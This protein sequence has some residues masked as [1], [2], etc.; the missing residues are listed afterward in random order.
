MNTQPEIRLGIGI[1]AHNEAGTLPSLV[2]SLFQQSIF[3][4][5]RPRFAAIHVVCIPNGCTDDTA[6]V[7]RAC[8]DKAVATLGANNVSCAVEELSTA[9]KANAWNHCIHNAL[10]AYEFV[11][12]LDADILFAS[13]DTIQAALRRV[14]EDA[15]VCVATDLPLK[16][17][18]DEKA[19]LVGRLSEA[20]SRASPPGPT[21]ICGQFYCARASVLRSIWI[22][23]GLP[24]EDG[25]LRAMVITNEFRQAEDPQR[26]VRADGASHFFESKR[27]LRELWRHKKRLMIGTTLNILLFQHLWDHAGEQGAGQLLRDHS[28]TDP[29]WLSQY[30]SDKVSRHYWVV[31][32]GHVLRRLGALRELPVPKAMKRVPVAL[33]ATVLDLAV[34]LSANREIKRGVGL[35]YW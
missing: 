8:L 17:P 18:G 15:R 9:G 26:I 25:F 29:S 4:Q 7:A 28:K 13:S 22:P 5:H 30:L 10:T 12:L 24:V 11:C 34:A 33:A 20:F 14:V 23:D 35:G 31:P 27:S 1:L 2:A 16:Q 19:S 21:E 6:A 3:H 32:M